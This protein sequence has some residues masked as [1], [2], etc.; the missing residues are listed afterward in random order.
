MKVGFAN[1]DILSVTEVN[2]SMNVEIECGGRKCLALLDTGCVMS[3]VYKEVS[4]DMKI[5]KRFNLK[6]M[7][8]GICD[9]SVPAVGKF[10]EK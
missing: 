6:G 2:D 10:R 3:L 7:I 1:V 9:I 4:D 8:K 5:E